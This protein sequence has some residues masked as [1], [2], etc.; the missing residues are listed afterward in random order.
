MGLLSLKRAGKDAVQRAMGAPVA[1]DF[2]SATL[3]VLQLSNDEPAQLVAAGCVEVP[4]N[5]RADVKRRL[6][7]QIDSL[8]K[9]VGSLPLRGRRAVCAIPAPLTFCKHAQ[10]GRQDGMP[11]EVLADGM[12][13]EQ[14][15]RDASTLVRKLL[16]VPGT[17]RSGAKHEYICLATGREIVDKLMKALRAA[18]LDVVGMHSE[19]EAAL[20]AFHTLNRRTADKYDATLYLDIGGGQTQV[21]IGHGPDLVFARSIAIGGLTLFVCSALGVGVRVCKARLVRLAMHDM[22]PAASAVPVPAPSAAARAGDEDGSVLVAE[23]RRGDGC[24][25]GMS[26]DLARAAP[27]PAAPAG[28]SLREPLEILTD[29][30][31]MCVRYHDTM[32]PSSRVS[33]VVFIGG[34]S[35]HRGL[36]Q[37][38]ARGLRLPAKVA[39]PLARVVRPGTEKAVGVDLSQP[40]PGWAVAVGLCH[41]PTDL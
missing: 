5:L 2:G 3:K 35:R 38:I 26:E 34:E 41:C 21:L 36:C 12:L 7:F 25:P 20:A 37:H 24:A 9:L 1:I 11:P 18:K 22:V 33:N 6:E 19:F 14:L 23:E 39:D 28:A 10:L 32:F 16:E 17:D 8:P 31:N 4:D 40:Q 15:G 29:E 13:T 27:T 30:T